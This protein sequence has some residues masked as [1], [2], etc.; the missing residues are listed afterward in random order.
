[1]KDSPNEGKQQQ[2]LV[3][4]DDND[5]NRLLYT[6]FIQAGYLT[7]QAFS[8]TEALLLIDKTI[9]LVVLDLMLPGLSGEE[10]IRKIRE[11]SNVSVI[12]VSGKAALEDRVN[13]LGLG[14]DDYIVKPFEKQD[15]LARVAAQLRRANVYQTP[16]Q[17]DETKQLYHRDLCL[18]IDCQLVTWKE[19]PIPLTQ[20]EFSILYELLK[21]PGQ[22]FSRDKLYRAIWNEDFIGDDNA[23]TVHISHLRQKLRQVS[24]IELITTVW[25][26][27]YKID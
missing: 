7:K 15:V 4:E 8:G 6:Y 24:G 23:I 5:I 27:G 19:Q 1:M 20:T 2:I 17:E 14:A 3:V 16:I 26:I 25:G 12:V 11:K 9:D 21:K 13:V 22:V 18:C 10:L